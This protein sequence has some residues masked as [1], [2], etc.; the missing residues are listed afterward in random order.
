MYTECVVSIASNKPRNLYIVYLELTVAI[1]YLCLTAGPQ[2]ST[3]LHQTHELGK[4]YVSPCSCSRSR[5]LMKKKNGWAI[6]F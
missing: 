4:L 6:D 1:G 3:T 2:H 5:I